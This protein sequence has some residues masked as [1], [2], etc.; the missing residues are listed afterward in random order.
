MIS[1]LAISANSLPEVAMAIK[2][3]RLAWSV[4]SQNRTYEPRTATVMGQGQY[5]LDITHLELAEACAKI[6]RWRTVT[7]SHLCSDDPLRR[8]GPI[9]LRE[10]TRA[11]I[12]DG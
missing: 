4:L 3:A 7:P 5:R 12:Q 8:E 11:N 9:C 10:R 6:T 1:C 2:L